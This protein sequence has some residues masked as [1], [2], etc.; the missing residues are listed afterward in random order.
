MVGQEPENATGES[1]PAAVVQAWPTLPPY[2][3]ATIRTR[4]DAT[5]R[6]IKMDLV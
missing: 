5:S 6:S 4:V 3:Q 2:V 1:G